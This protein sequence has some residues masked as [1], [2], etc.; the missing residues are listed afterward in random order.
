MSK[1]STM[2]LRSPFQ[3][4]VPAA[5]SFQV[6]MMGSHQESSVRVE[7]LRPA[8]Q[9]V[10]AHLDHHVLAQS[11]AFGFP[12]IGKFFK[13]TTDDPA[14]IIVQFPKDGRRQ[15]RPVHL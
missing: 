5:D 10:A 12:L 2:A 11:A 13:F 9:M 8:A 1:S 7:R 3:S 15:G 14:I 6:P 4:Y